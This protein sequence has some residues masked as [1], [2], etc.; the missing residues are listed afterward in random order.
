MN[1]LAGQAIE[2][3]DK[4]TG[5]RMGIILSFSGKG[6]R[7]L[8]LNRKETTIPER[9]ILHCTAISRASTSD[10]DRCMASAQDL[11]ERR[12]VLA[13]AIDLDGLHALLADDIRSYS[14]AELAGFAGNAADEDFAAALL[15]RLSA[16][17]WYFREKKDAWIPVPRPEVEEAKARDEKNR[18]REAED[19]LF[20]ADLKAVWERGAAA[21][22]P[23]V[24]E[25]VETLVDLVVKGEASSAPKR[26]RD[27]LQAGGWM[28]PRKLFSLLAKIGRFSP[29]ENLM[30]IEY[31]VPTEFSADVLKEAASLKNGPEEGVG[32]LTPRDDGVPA[33]D[34]REKLTVWAIDSVGTNDRDDAFSILPGADGTTTLWVHVTDVAAYIRPGSAMDRESLRRGTSIYMPDGNIPMLPPSLSEDTLSLNQDTD[35]RVVSLRMVVDSAGNIIEFSPLMALIRVARAVDY[36]EGDSLAASGEPALVAALELAERLRTQRK[37]AGAIIL[38]RPELNLRVRDGN[39]KVE[40]NFEKSPTSEMI[41]EFMI[42]ANHLAALWCRDRGI[43]CLY[44][45]QEKPETVVEMGPT[46]DAVKFYQAI[47]QFKRTT[48]TT[49]PG[50]H[51]CLG[52]DPY[53]Q[54]T[55]PMRRYSDL[56]LQR[57]IRDVL[58][59][60]P[61]AFDV[62]GLEST[63]R[64]ADEGLVVGE[65]VMDYRYRYFLLKH[66]KAEQN[67]GRDTSPA[68]VVDQGPNDVQI[69]NEDLLEL[70][71]CRRPSFDL[72]VGTRVTLKYKL[73]D[74][75]EGVLKYE[76]QAVIA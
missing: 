16:D 40:R 56:L 5:L 18:L 50:R 21:V 4:E 72:A 73:I 55:S 39:I 13:A 36:P 20:L 65:K 54:I 14:P 61:P 62:N 9:A 1:Y 45:V 31:Q 44:R 68:V 38:S 2:F 58:A 48:I 35:R 33:L 63:M 66:L 37:A 69:Y 25:Q 17:S 74:P 43:A 10:L 7:V 23:K 12:R 11:D 53:C 19:Q 70:G 22:T 49:N 27:L 67:A 34:L 57:Q 3:Q 47:R 32:I 64:M 26:L 76:V 75:F 46:F 29:D 8:L 24:N 42:W 51:G 52:V 28:A 60:R 30:V 71:R 6:V 59:G 41:A 15:R